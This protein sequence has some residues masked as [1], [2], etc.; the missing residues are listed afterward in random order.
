[1]DVA[2]TKALSS[3]LEEKTI[4]YNIDLFIANAGVASIDGMSVLDQSETILQI[5]MLGAIAG[6][7]AVFKAYKKRGH[8]GQ[9]AC[10]ASVFGLMDPPHTISYGASKAGIISY[11]RD[12]RTLGK[13]YG[14]TVNTIAPGFIQTPMT[15]GFSV[16]RGFFLTPELF[17]EKVKHDLANDVALVSYPVYQYLFFG[18]LS[19]LPPAIKQC[20]SDRMHQFFD[21]HV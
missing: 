16:K 2:D 4:E 14:I 5:N 17:A 1:M 19:I 3:F 6:M 15:S 9:I 8:G 13:E 21:K 12:L 10:V 20:V 18:I 7:N 11:G